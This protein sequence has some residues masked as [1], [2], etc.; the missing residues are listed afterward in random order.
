MHGFA[1]FRT[2]EQQGISFAVVTR[3][4]RQFFTDAPPEITSWFDWDL[5]LAGQGSWPLYLKINLIAERALS[6]PHD[7]ARNITEW[8]STRDDMVINAKRL[9]VRPEIAPER[10][11]LRRAVAKMMEPIEEA[12]IDTRKDLKLFYPKN[13][14]WLIQVWHMT[15]EPP[16]IVARLHITGWRLELEHLSR[17]MG[18]TVDA[19]SFMDRIR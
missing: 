11:P 4:L 2:I 19:P 6:Q 12:G 18:H 15:T 10:R 8:L 9:S 3:W 5:T 13:S 1:T 17:L 7:K 14:E 16:C